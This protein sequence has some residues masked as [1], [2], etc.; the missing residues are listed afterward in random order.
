MSEEIKDVCV[1]WDELDRCVKWK[2]SS[3]GKIVADFGKCDL[4]NKD[5]TIDEF[6]KRL[7]RGVTI[8]E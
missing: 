2:K 1:E 5:D 3:D 8:K 7:R 4:K 6:A